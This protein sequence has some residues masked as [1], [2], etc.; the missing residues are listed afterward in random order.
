M[1]ATLIAVVI[2]LAVLV[3]LPSAVAALIGGRRACMYAAAVTSWLLAVVIGLTGIESAPVEI[4][5][6]IVVLSVAATG[7]FIGAAAPLVESP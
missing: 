6:A 1:I 3:G 7:I 4:R 2:I 5:P